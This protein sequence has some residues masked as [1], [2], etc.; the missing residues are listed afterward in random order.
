ML[1]PDWPDGP[2][3]VFQDF[4]GM[5][6][7]S[8]LVLGLFNLLPIPPM[9]GGRIVVGVLPLKLAIRWARLERAGIFLVLLGVFVLPALLREFGIDF[10]PVGDTL[11]TVIPRAVDLVLRLA[12]HDG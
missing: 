6:L 8:N 2:M 4:L 1:P 9:D 3:T 12:G 7:F 10:D 5:F 11:N